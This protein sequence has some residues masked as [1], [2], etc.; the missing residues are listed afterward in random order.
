MQNDPRNVKPNEF[1]RRLEQATCSGD[2]WK[3]FVGLNLS[4]GL[5]I[6]DYVFATGYGNWW[7][8]R[9]VNTTFNSKWI[10]FANENENTRK[11]SYFRSHAVKHL[12][13]ILV[14]I[15]YLDEMQ[16]LPP[17]RLESLE[18]ARSLGLNAGMGIPLRMNSPGQAA[19]MV[20]GGA[21]NRREFDAILEKHG[22][23]LAAAAMAAHTLYIRYFNSEFAIR[24]GLTKEQMELLELVGQG[25]MDKEIADRLGISL[26]AVRQRLIAVQA[27]T[28][29]RNRIDLA[30]L[31]VRIGLVEDP[32]LRAHSN[33]LTVFI[34]TGDDVSGV[35]TLH[36]DRE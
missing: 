22:M 7:N 13:P 25:L 29:T 14:G 10:G 15:E 31:A 8:T 16:P 28:V 23:M 36:G 19:I 32:C 12:T 2:V 9:F 17:G 27:K 33:E 21:L 35:E 5:E 6:V 3:E 1:L 26:S 4:V 34:T 11:L 18:F 20:L 30:A 24:S